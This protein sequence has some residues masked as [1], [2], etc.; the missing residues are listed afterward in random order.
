[1]DSDPLSFLIRELAENA[2]NQC[3]KGGQELARWIQ[4][5]CQ[6]VF[7]EIDLYAI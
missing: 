7:G 6:S 3:D 1:V 5:N 4:L 2:V